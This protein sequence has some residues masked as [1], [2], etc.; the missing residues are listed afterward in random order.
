LDVLEDVHGEHGATMDLLCQLRYDEAGGHIELR[1]LMF[2]GDL[3]DRRSKCV[4][5]KQIVHAITIP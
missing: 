1:T 4:L 2:L 5:A 3:C